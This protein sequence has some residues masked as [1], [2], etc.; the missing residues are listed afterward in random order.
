VEIIELPN[1]PFFIATQFHPEFHSR[2]NTP[3]P[4]FNG[5]IKAASRQGMVEGQEE[6]NSQ[7]SMRSQ[8]N[9]STNDSTDRENQNPDSSVELTPVT[10]A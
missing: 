4:L 6:E 3:H 7:G 5:L 2:P 10:G 8:L 9:D 1:H